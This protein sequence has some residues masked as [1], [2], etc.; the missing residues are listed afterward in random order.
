M[1]NIVLKGSTSGDVTITVPAAAGTNTVSLPAA[2]G[3]LPLSNLIHVTNRPNVK[4]IVINGDMRISTRGTSVT[5]ITD[6]GYHSL[7]RIALDL[8]DNGTWTQTLST[9]VPAGQGFASSLKMDCT[10]ADSAVATGAFHLL[11]YKIEGRDCQLFKKGTSSAEYITVAFWIKSNLTGTFTTEIFDSQGDDRNI[12]K[13]FTIDSADTWE[14]KVLSFVGDT[15][16]AQP[17]TSALGL[18][19]NIWMTGGATFTGGTLQTAWG[20]KTDN[21]RADTSVN[22]ASSTDNEYY[23]TGLQ[24]EV[25][26]YTASTLPP[27]QFE[28]LQDSQM[29]C[30]RY[31]QKMVSANNN[32]VG[33]GFSS[34]GDGRGAT[35]ID[36]PCAMRAG[37]T[38]TTSAA[39]TF[40]FAIGTNASG[41]GSGFIVK[42]YFSQAG[43]NQGQGFDSNQNF[44]V[45]LDISASGLS[46]GAFTRG[47]SNGDSFVQLEAEI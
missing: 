9:D 5:G 35:L 4:P 32:F 43:M 22:I 34:D 7:D 1:S 24:V 8:S 6:T 11:R 17:N 2:T 46:N 37:P 27:F 44:V 12:S 28:T 26:E 47:V 36:T 18:S 41:N 29:R 21:E 45:W 33:R 13:T 3:S 30:A 19:V 23:L 25:G 39:S 15:S 42:G 31:C 14:K 40:K 10:T 38:I 20:A 16:V